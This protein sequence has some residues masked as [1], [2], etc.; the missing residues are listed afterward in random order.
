[1]GWGFF[2]KVKDAVKKA[3][4]WMRDK[5]INP[6]VKPIVKTGLDVIKK[7]GPEI[8]TAFG[9]MKGNPQLGMKIGSMVQQFVPS[10]NKIIK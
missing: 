7:Y 6:V 5:V 1:M 4:K 2:K 3:G 8:G 9:S 10:I